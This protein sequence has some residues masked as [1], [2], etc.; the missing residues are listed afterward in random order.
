MVFDLDRILHPVYKNKVNLHTFQKQH[1]KIKYQIHI[2]NIYSTYRICTET[3]TYTQPHIFYFLLSY[4]Q[5]FMD[6]N[7]CEAAVYSMDIVSAATLTQSYQGIRS[8][9]GFKEVIVGHCKIHCT[10]TNS[11]SFH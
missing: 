2:H 7:L 9:K 1:D 4:Q 3:N 8:S 10:K 6:N 11:L 5:Y